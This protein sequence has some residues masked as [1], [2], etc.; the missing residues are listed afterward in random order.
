MNKVW[1]LLCAGA[2]VILLVSCARPFAREGIY[3]FEEKVYETAKV[4]SPAYPMRPIS[5][6]V[7]APTVPVVTETASG[8]KQKSLRAVNVGKDTG[9]RCFEY[10]NAITNTTSKQWKIVHEAEVGE[11]GFL[12]HSEY[13]LAAIGHGWGYVI[14]DIV[15]ITTDQ[16]TYTIVVGDYKAY[17]D[18]DSTHKIS[19]RSGCV[20]EFIVSKEHLDSRIRRAG[21][22][23]IL[24]Q[25]KGLVLNMEKVGSIW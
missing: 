22:V 4:G 12:Y 23:A 16:S 11:Y 3:T 25:Y 14:G 8:A 18:T 19:Y 5:D 9:F 17:K 20:C 24:D 2:C 13:P 10:S 6:C 21:N 15:E 7:C 1:K